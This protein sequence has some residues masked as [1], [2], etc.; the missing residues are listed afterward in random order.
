MREGV[1]VRALDA[2]P[3]MVEMARQRGVH[4]H[5]SAIEEVHHLDGEYSGAIS[6]FGALNCVE[7][8]AEVRH[9]LARLVKQGG[10]LAICL[11]GRF[12]LLESLY[13]LR[14]LQFRKAVRRWRGQSYVQKLSMKVFYPASGDVIRAMAPD[15]RLVRR[16][17]IGLA[18]PPS[19][20]AGVS[21]T[22]MHVREDID[23]RIAHWPFM[24]SMADHQL[25]IF[26]RE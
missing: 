26:V 2:S 19:Y 20:V 24:K 13:Y 21:P 8:L 17:G 6:N 23:R 11:M 1:I 25:F 12:C 9:S 7:N 4:A 3:K 14:H 18:V 16:T 10:C 22:S 5:V 15:F